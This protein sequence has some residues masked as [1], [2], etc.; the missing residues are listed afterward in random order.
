M[1]G[2]DNHEKENIWYILGR[3]SVFDF[4]LQI[5]VSQTLSISDCDDEFQ[6]FDR[7]LVLTV[8]VIEMLITNFEYLES[9]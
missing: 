7:N 6:S 8:V 5:K 2:I 9:Y 4:L 3:T 1:C